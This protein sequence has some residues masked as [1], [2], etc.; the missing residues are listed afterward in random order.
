MSQGLRFDFSRA[1]RRI[2]AIQSPCPGDTALAEANWLRQVPPHA[3]HLRHS[4]RLQGLEPWTVPSHHRPE[5]L[6]RPNWYPARTCAASMCPK[7]PSKT[8]NNMRMPFKVLPFE[9]YF[10]IR[11]MGQTDYHLLVCFEGAVGC[12]L[13]LTLTFHL[14]LSHLSHAGPL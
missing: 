6:G 11:P 1:S 13:L 9:S 2:N 7:R 14:R 3:M 10:L 5:K 12:T 4:Q 8:R